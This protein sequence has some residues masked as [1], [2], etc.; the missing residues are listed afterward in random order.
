MYRLK[1]LCSLAKLM[2]CNCG[3]VA[4]AI[5][6]FVVIWFLFISLFCHRSGWV[7]VDSFFFLLFYWIFFWYIYFSSLLR[8]HSLFISLC[9][10]GCFVWYCSRSSTECPRVALH[11][12]PTLLQP[13]PFKHTPFMFHTS[14]VTLHKHFHISC[15]PRCV[16]MKWDPTNICVK[17][18]KHKRN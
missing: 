11:T 6:V 3:S 13:Q 16:K 18:K 17:K 1:F 12:N 4:V 15:I 5:Y 2:S 7:A 10:F 14:N 9:C 8:F